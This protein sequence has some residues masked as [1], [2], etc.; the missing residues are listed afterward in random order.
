MENKGITI[1]YKRNTFGQKQ[2]KLINM[3]NLDSAY[4]II[5]Q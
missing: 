3:K 2:I 4:Q 1:S 5:M